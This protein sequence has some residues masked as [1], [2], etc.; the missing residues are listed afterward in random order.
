M[1]LED[2]EVRLVRVMSVEIE[3]IFHPKFRQLLHILLDDMENPGRIIRTVWEEK[4]IRALIGAT[5][6]LGSKQMIDLKL[7]L[8]NR[9][10]P[11][12]MMVPKNSNVNSVTPEEI[13]K[14]KNFEKP[15]NNRNRNRNRNKRKKTNNYNTENRKVN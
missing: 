13:I 15:K 2:Y 5:E 10:D 8:E 4:D 7:S 9:E 1:N 3:E 14:Y 12:R 11:I 6:P